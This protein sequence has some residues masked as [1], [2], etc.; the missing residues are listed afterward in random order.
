MSKN[1]KQKNYKS[2]LIWHKVQRDFNYTLKKIEDG[3][4][5]AKVPLEAVRI[6]TKGVELF[7][8]SKRKSLDLKGQ[9][10]GQKLVNRLKEKYGF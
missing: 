9:K 8:F 4:F 6:R 2:S 1:L 7:N 3:K 5:P 10:A